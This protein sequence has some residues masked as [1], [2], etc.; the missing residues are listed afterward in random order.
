MSGWRPIAEVI[1]ELE[2]S[3]KGNGP[4]P[5]PMPMSEDEEW[6]RMLAERQLQMLKTYDQPYIPK[7]K[8]INGIEKTMLPGKIN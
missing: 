2:E 3:L 7:V 1:K 6:K 8:F 5:I 4:N